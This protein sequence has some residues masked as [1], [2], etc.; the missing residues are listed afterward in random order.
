MNQPPEPLGLLKVVKTPSMPVRYEDLKTW[1][2]KNAFEEYKMNMD[3]VFQLIHAPLFAMAAGK[4]ESAE[5]FTDFADEGLLLDSDVNEL[6]DAVM[7]AG[8]K[9]RETFD[10]FMKSIIVQGWTVMEMMMEDLWVRAVNSEPV[11]LSQHLKLPDKSKITLQEL[12]G[13]NFNLSGEL[14]HYLKTKINFSMADERTNAYET[15]FKTDMPV[16]S[17]A[18]EIT[19]QAL[20]HLR[21]VIAH[22][23][24]VIDTKF[25]HKAKCCK[26]L[27][28]VAQLGLSAKISIN[29]D[30]IAEFVWESFQRGAT[31]V[32]TVDDWLVKHETR[33]KRS[34]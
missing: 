17:A 20:A 8:P 6:E 18:K 25:L 11:K 22:S 10:S 31:L 34:P 32:K 1:P 12:S 16:T 13:Y 30:L 4:G 26:P 14:G 29:G 5:L 3:R 7:R 9:V 27:A 23:N 2:A 19:F 33:K 15:A 21:N 28:P 24:G